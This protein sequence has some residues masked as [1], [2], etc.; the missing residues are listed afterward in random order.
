LLGTSPSQPGRMGRSGCRST[1]GGTSR[2]RQA[3]SGIKA[4]LD[5][6]AARRAV[7]IGMLI[8][9]LWAGWLTARQSSLVPCQ[10]RYA[11]AQAR[12]TAQRAAA[13]SEDRAALDKMV[14]AFVSATSPGDGRTAL[15]QYQ[16]TRKAADDKRARNPF[17]AP[18]SKFC[19]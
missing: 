8:Y 6:S 13:A 15:L 4:W 16:A 7:V 5:S 11:E 12:S 2:A 1:L 18:P 17:P 14:D 10:A 19:S 9:F 3:M